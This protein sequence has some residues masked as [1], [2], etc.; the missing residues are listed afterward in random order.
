MSP[1]GSTV[2]RRARNLVR[3]MVVE[4][5]QLIRTGPRGFPS[6]PEAFTASSTGRIHARGR[7][8]IGNGRLLTRGGPYI[9]SCVRACK[10]ASKSAKHQSLYDADS[11]RSVCGPRNAGTESGISADARMEH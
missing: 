1:D 5:D 3:R 2:Y 7:F 10:G 4:T 11:V 9:Y 6:W 8:F